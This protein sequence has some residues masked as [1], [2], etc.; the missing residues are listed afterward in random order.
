MPDA[1]LGGIMNGL[2]GPVRRL[3]LAML[4]GGVTMSAGVS[5]GEGSRA[6]GHGPGLIVQPAPPATVD[7]PGLP[8]I[9]APCRPTGPQAPSPC[10]DGVALAGGG[11]KAAAYAM[12]VLAAVADASSDARPFAGIGAISSVSGGGYAAYYLYSKLALDRPAGDAPMPAAALQRYFADCLPDQY[13]GGLG[14]VLTDKQIQA[15]QQR[16]PGAWC[17]RAGPL[18][19]FRFQQFVRCRQDVLEQD[20]RPSM[21]ENDR[22]SNNTNAALLVTATA[23]SVVP[24]LLARTV[25]DWP[26]NLSVTRAAYRQGIGSAYGLYP[27]RWPLVRDGQTLG[28]DGKIGDVVNVCTADNFRNCQRQS[29]HPRSQGSAQV[30]PDTLTFE[31]L[32][33][34]TRSRQVPL[35]IINATA[36]KNRSVFGWARAGQRD[37]SRYTMHMT[38]EG[39]YSGF[40]GSFDAAFLAQ[41]LDPLEAVVT[42]AAFFDSSETAFAQ[43]WRL[44][45]AL[46]QHALVLDWGIDIPN[47]QVPVPQQLVHQMLPTAPWPWSGSAIR[48]VPTYFADGVLRSIGHAG[49]TDPSGDF[50]GASAFIR[51]SDGGNNDNLGAAALVQAGVTRLFVSD[52]A[53]DRDGTMQDLCRL[54]NELALRFRL[55]LVVPALADLDCHCRSFLDESERFWLPPA[56]HHVIDGDRPQAWPVTSKRQRD[57][58][59]RGYDIHAWPRP[60]LVGCIVGADVSD[61]D[62]IER[63]AAGTDTAIAARRVFLVKP[64]LDLAAVRAVPPQLPVGLA[65]RVAGGGMAEVVGY[66]HERGVDGRHSSDAFPQHSTFFMTFASDAARFGAYRELGRFQM[67]Q[68]LRLRD[69]GDAAFAQEMACQR[70][71]LRLTGDHAPRPAAPGCDDAWGW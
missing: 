18:S 17:S 30:V 47:P 3:I 67:A 41:H 35:W 62:T 13:A 8:A 11:T 55:K 34:M 12:G 14:K 52:H 4:A 53:Q 9:L 33:Q 36:A 38:P 42:A 19:D 60:V 23:L 22:A 54:H 70:D 69:A 61:D 39:M 20:C 6:V 45:W 31:T 63:C 48:P 10:T 16:G 68:A 64:A 32:R 66:V 21:Q 29:F 49:R 15:R 1:G 50:P 5:A 46:A 28:S 51:L 25:F 40:F 57:E 43:P 37:F 65:R 7:Q 2:V 59:Q 56:P 26:V 24:N 58:R 44:G 27:L 71:M